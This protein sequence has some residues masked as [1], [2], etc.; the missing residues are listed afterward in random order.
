[1]QLIFA[2]LHLALFYLQL[3]H[4][5]SPRQAR[6]WTCTRVWILSALAALSVVFDA[7]DVYVQPWD[8][9]WAQMVYTIVM[10]VG[11]TAFLWFWGSRVNQRLSTCTTS[12]RLAQ[13]R[14]VS[15]KVRNTVWYG[16]TFV[17]V[18]GVGWFFYRQMFLVSVSRQGTSTFFSLYVAWS[19]VW[20]CVLPFAFVLMMG[21]VAMPRRSQADLAMT[22]V[23]DWKRGKVLYQH[24]LGPAVS[25]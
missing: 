2:F 19:I 8:S 16:A 3:I 1:M 9:M 10:S 11:A 4:S 22:S 15:L 7:L 5:F 18:R 25:T 24:C 21:G 23:V 6:W 20:N 12:S 17:C 13:T 14:R